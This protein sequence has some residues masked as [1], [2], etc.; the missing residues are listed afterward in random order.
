[1]IINLG[2]SENFGSIDFAHLTFPNHLRVD[3]IR[4]Y[5]PMHSVN[6]GCNPPDYPTEK[7]INACV[8]A[9][10]PSFTFLYPHARESFTDE[11]CYN[12]ALPCA[13]IVTLKHIQT[14]I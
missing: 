10:L 7:Y 3:Y 14:R 11:I 8:L 12:L 4:V 5:Q 9:S 6:I 2:M 13:R 1:M